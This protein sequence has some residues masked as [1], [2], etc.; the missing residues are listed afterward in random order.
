MS[1]KSQ[2][3]LYDSEPENV[4]TNEVVQ[5]E[6]VQIPQDIPIVAPIPIRPIRAPKIQT[7]V[8]PLE[9]EAKTDTFKCAYCDYVTLYV[10]II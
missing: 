9:I 10:T 5:T 8:K 7:V 6:A 2:E 1:K 3:I 4:E